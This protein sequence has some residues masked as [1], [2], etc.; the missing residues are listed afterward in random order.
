MTKGIVRQFS[1]CVVVGSL[2]AGSLV[3]CV[4]EVTGGGSEGGGGDS[5]TNETSET[6][7][8]STGVGGPVET[9]SGGT[10]GAPTTGS[11]GQGGQAFNAIALTYAQLEGTGGTG[12]AGGNGS[13][14][15]GS[16]GGPDPLTQFLKYGGGS[17]LPTCSMPNGTGGC[18][19][20]NVSISIQSAAFQTGTF[21]FADSNFDISMAES[22]VEGGG[23]CSGGGGGGIEEGEITIVSIN[24]AEV[25][26]IVSGVP[27]FLEQDPNGEYFAT[28][29]Q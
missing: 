19:G 1:F 12:G 27:V 29:C 6:S 7:E 24:A 25:H 23:S 2:F 11:T 9:G 4:G 8:G 16:G 20:W 17:D 18:G 5:E 10:G 15:Q 26:F 13:S 14:G 28:R 3:G 21:A 22:M